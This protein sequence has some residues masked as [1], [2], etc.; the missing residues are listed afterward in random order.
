LE[1]C[2]VVEGFLHIVLME[3]LDFASDLNNRSFPALREITG[4]LLFYRVFGLRSIGQLFPNLAVIRGQQLLFDFSF[5]VYEL[6]QLQVRS[7]SLV[8]L[9][10]LVD[11]SC[12]FLCF[13]ICVI[14]GFTQQEIGLKSLAEL[15]RGSVLIE[16]NPNLCYVESIDWGRIGHSGRL[17]HFI[18]VIIYVV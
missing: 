7:F 4:Y 17:N 5:V 10:F 1:G 11:M 9:G 16:K 18:Q 6:M 8:N 13:N 14:L 12:R 3:N 15:Q 2:R